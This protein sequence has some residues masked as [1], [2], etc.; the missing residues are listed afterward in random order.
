MVLCSTTPAGYFDRKIML[1]TTW[2]AIPLV[3]EKHKNINEFHFTPLQFY[4]EKDIKTTVEK[5]KENV[6]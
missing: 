5:F 3:V 6:I 1:I 2:G 4:G